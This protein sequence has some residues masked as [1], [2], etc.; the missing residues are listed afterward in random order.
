MQVTLSTPRWLR[1]LRWHTHN[2]VHCPL[3]HLPCF[4]VLD[5]QFNLTTTYDD[6]TDIHPGPS[7]DPPGARPPQRMQK[8]PAPSAL[9]VTR[10]VVRRP[11]LPFLPL[12]VQPSG[13]SPASFSS[14]LL[15]STYRNRVPK[16]EDCSKLPG[17]NSAYTHVPRVNG[18]DW[19]W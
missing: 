16:V 13:A 8:H 2:A 5:A 19:K 18:R 6:H 14:N 9:P 10:A 3:S 15:A 17:G 12:A 1:T 4:P 11:P 7:P